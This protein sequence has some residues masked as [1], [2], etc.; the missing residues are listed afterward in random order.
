VLIPPHLATAYP[1]RRS[2]AKLK[3][4]GQIRTKGTNKSMR[5]TGCRI[6]DENNDLVIEVVDPRD[7]DMADKILQT[8]DVDRNEES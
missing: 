6:F 5:A 1:F 8:V 7:V 2:D 4:T 3:I